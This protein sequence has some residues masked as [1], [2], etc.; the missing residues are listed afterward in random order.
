MTQYFFLDESGDPGQ[1]SSR[2]FALGAVQLP[3]REPVAELIALRRKL[4]LSPT[5]EFKY[6]KTTKSQNELFFHSI[7]PLEFRV[8][9]VIVDKSR[10]HID[11]GKYTGQVFVVEWISRLILRASELDIADDILIIDGAV[12][13]LRNALR[14]RLSDECRRYNR[15]RPFSKIVGVDSSREDGLQ[16]ADMIIGAT[17]QHIIESNSTYFNTFASKVVDLWIAP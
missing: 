15:K 9:A 2:Y 1:R 6:H 3:K 7:Q 16:L 13:S 12:P 5:F 17:C 4:N 11:W 10:L 14:I 8:R